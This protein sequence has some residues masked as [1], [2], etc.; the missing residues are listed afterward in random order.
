MSSHTRIWCARACA[1]VASAIALGAAA[2][3]APAAQLL[4]R[5]A[6]DVRLTVSTDGKALVRYRAN[7]REFH[8]LAWGAVNAIAPTTTRKQV[9]L[10]LDYSGGWN[11][12]HRRVASFRGSCRPYRGPALHWLV[13]A[14]AAPDGTFWALQSW[15][16][17]LPNYGMPASSFQ[18]APELRLSHW[19]GALPRLDV[20]IG[21]AQ[22]RY[23]TV[24][25]RFT[26]KGVG[27]YGFH[28][29]PQGAPLDTFGRLMY[30]DT[31]DSQYGS[32]WQRENSFLTHRSGGTFCY[33]FFPH[34][35]RPAGMGTRYRAT[36][37]SPGVLPDMYW[38]GV[39]P[40]TYE[41][42]YDEAMTKQRDA[43]DDP[44]CQGV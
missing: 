33:G 39:P 21:W 17:A 41:A 32:G 40:R 38:E 5:S 28:A 31:F 18:R 7:G 22:R 1:L 9:S 16:R 42:A 44:S 3:P 25:G 14:C 10:K 13:T 34:A 12:F 4:G 2:A 8:I 36:M 37:M 19:S 27:V 11:S 26:Y 23:H 24:F 6:T 20:Y 30:V 43:L 15:Q 35:P 29:T